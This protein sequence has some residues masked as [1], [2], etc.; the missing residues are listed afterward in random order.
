[1]R[2]GSSTW[3]SP[4]L[5][6]IPPR[7]R[8]KSEARVVS[9]SMQMDSPS[10]VPRPFL[11]LLGGINCRGGG[12]E[13]IGGKARVVSNKVLLLCYSQV[14]KDHSQEHH[15]NDVFGCTCIDFG[16]QNY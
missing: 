10:L 1:M 16:V 12:E 14:V 7:R 2:M 5:Q 6:L 15:K 13:G 4:P 9:S 3:P 11:L 8:R